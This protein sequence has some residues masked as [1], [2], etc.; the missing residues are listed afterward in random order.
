MTVREL[1][2]PISVIAA[3]AVTGRMVLLSIDARDTPLWDSYTT[4]GQYVRLQLEDPVPRPY[5]IASPPGAPMEF[6]VKLPA[7]RTADMAALGP[8]DRIMASHAL[9]RGFD[10]RRAADKHL[11]LFCVGSGIAPMRALVE[12]LMRSRSAYGDVTLVYGVRTKADLVFGERFG[13]WAGHN[14]GVQPVLS[15]PDAG[16]LG[17]TGY[18]QDHM[19]KV[20]DRPDA[21]A[22][23]V[24]GLPDMDKAVTAQLL[25]RGVGREQVLR[26]F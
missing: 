15:R 4:P 11:W 22:A 13:A 20:F 26:N 24:C 8:T 17:R 2:H 21:V 7:E 18:V 25:E 1:L 9:G 23:F 6:L 14:I 3:K 16:W 5:A 12:T 10:L 19:P